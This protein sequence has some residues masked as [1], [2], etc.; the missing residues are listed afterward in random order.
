MRIALFDDSIEFDGYIPSTFP[1]GG[2]EKAFA[3]LAGALAARGHDVT[4]FN[5]CSHNQEIEGARWRTWDSARPVETDALIAF[6]RPSLLQEVRKAAKRVLWLAGTPEPLA[7]PAIDKL[8]G[9]LK[10]TLVFIG[11][12]QA[13]RWRGPRLPWTVIPPGVSET[14]L[15]GGRFGSSRPVA[16]TTTHPAHGL[17]WLVDLWVSGIHPRCPTAELH[18]YSAL[19]SR[20]DLGRALPEEYRPLRAKIEAAAAQGVEVREPQGD[21]SMAL[22]YRAARVHLYPGHRDDMAC[23]TLGESQACGVPAVA[24]P[25]GAVHERIENGVTGYIVPDNDAFANVAA[26]V[27][28]DD[29]IFEGLSTAAAAQARVR[30]WDAVAQAFEGVLR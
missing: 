9:S 5:R 3:A 4:V 12:T 8:L 24:R 22:A 16:V 2:A 19:L 25:V 29:G 14:Y 30:S 11:S 21:V 18:I 10:P 27:L 7:K 26:Q 20:P 17:E 15:S 13:A 6:R 1:L 23:W 28:S